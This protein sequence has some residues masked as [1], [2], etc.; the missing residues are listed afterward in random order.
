MFSNG[1]IMTG[2]SYCLAHQ[3]A[4]ARGRCI[5]AVNDAAKEKKRKF[6]KMLTL[7]QK[8][9]IGRAFNT[10]ASKAK[11]AE[12]GE[13]ALRFLV[14]KFLRPSHEEGRDMKVIRQRC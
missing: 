2:H 1:Y 7:V 5:I 9:E 6:S 3:H 8:G 14:S 10:M 11:P 13:T 12:G 4:P